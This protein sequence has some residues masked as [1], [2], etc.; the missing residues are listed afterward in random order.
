MV[1]WLE[2]RVVSRTNVSFE[3]TSLP[4]S[5]GAQILAAF[6]IAL[7]PDRVQLEFE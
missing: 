2:G 1:F 3:P 5:P 6:L 4:Q 7:I